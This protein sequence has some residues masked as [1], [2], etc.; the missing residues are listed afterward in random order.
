MSVEHPEELQA[1]LATL[2]PTTR[3][4]VAEAD[5]AEQTVEW[6]HSPVGQYIIGC[7]KQEIAEAQDELSRVAPW[8]RRRI[9]DLQNRVWRATQ[10]LAWLRE[11][12]LGG[13][14]ARQ[15]LAES[16]DD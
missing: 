1:I 9:Q 4:L 16:D 12:V 5:L 14:A 11:L 3:G 6:L 2:D 15:A 7:A 13:H 8:R 10:L